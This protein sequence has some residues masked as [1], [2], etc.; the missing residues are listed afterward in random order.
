MWKLNYST[1]PFCAVFITESNTKEQ[2]CGSG[3]CTAA[4][5]EELP[6]CHWPQSNT[7]FQPSALPKLLPVT[8]LTLI[9]LVLRRV[10]K[11]LELH[12]DVDLNPQ[13]QGDL[14]EDQL[15]LTNTCTGRR[16]KTITRGQSFMLWP[17]EEQ[18]V[19]GTC[20]W[21]SR[22][23]ARLIVW[24]LQQKTRERLLEMCCFS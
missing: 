10:D 19:F 5:T 23:P 15:E 17:R 4:H 11:T 1:C 7:T 14:Q 21:L 24:L 13:D 12:V 20:P 22:Q 8:L 16:Q 3:T 9:L 18:R 6:Y 2:P